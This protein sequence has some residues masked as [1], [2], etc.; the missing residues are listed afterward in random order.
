MANPVNFISFSD[1]TIQT[2][3][4]V[5]IDTQGGFQFGICC[6]FASPSLHLYVEAPNSQ[7]PKIRELS[8]T[9]LAV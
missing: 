6:A 3:S 7:F 1:T 8:I 9:N 2:A 5:V 4:I